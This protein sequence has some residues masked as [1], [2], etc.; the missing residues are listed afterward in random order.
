M[1]KILERAVPPVPNRPLIQATG[2]AIAK[3]KGLAPL[4]DPLAIRS[5]ARNPGRMP[6]RNLF[7]SN[8]S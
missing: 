4:G 6:R 2:T 5:Y 3:Q 7:L 8:R 1:G